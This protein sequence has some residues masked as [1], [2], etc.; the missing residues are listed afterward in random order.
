L[1][2]SSYSFFSFGAP[3]PE[4]LSV[5]V[6]C[7]AA[8]LA[9]ALLAAALLAA[10]LLFAEALAELAGLELADSFASLDLPPQPANAPSTKILPVVTVSERRNLVFMFFYP[11]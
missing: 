6:S 4:N 9:A 5:T 1:I 10:A 3:Q 7:G 2:K 8:L 11:P